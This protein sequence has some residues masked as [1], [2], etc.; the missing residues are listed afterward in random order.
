MSSPV[1]LMQ[2]LPAVILADGSFWLPPPDSSAAPAVDFVF[3]LILG[4]CAFFY[5]LVVGTMVY[6]S[7]MYR[8]RPGH[9]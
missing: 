6:F 3:Y 4:V 9:R 5:V 2:L 8:R 7:V 1:S